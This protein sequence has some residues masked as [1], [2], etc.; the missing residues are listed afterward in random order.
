MVNQVRY[1]YE[2]EMGAKKAKNIKEVKKMLGRRTKSHSNVFKD[3][4]STPLKC[5]F[6]PL[7]AIW[8]L[9]DTSTNI[10]RV[11]A[12]LFMRVSMA[13]GL[14]DKITA[15]DIVTKFQKK[16]SLNEDVIRRRTSQ[17]LTGVIVPTDDPDTQEP[18]IEK[19]VS[20][21]EQFLH[22]VGGNIGEY[23]TILVCWFES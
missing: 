3:H 17:N 16:S 1:L 19:V 9:Q 11:R 23:S 22:E 7:H 13:V 10:I 15:G 5:C 12:P 4:V 14:S 18:T 21:D 6:F 2:A 8:C 20:L